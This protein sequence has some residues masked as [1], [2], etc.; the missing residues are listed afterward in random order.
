MIAPKDSTSLASNAILGQY[1]YTST[2]LRI[3][4]S[5]FGRR[6]ALIGSQISLQSH[7]R[8]HQ[9]CLYRQRQSPE[10][11]TDQTSTTIE[12]VDATVEPDTTIGEPTSTTTEPVTETDEPEAITTATAETTSTP[13]RLSRQR[14]TQRT[15]PTRHLQRLSLSMPQSSLIQQLQN[16]HHH[17]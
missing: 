11:T 15:Q 1:R 13:V 9:P 12:S 6:R 8:P 3:Q 17:N 14:Q 10:D 16:R 2:F 7:R 5:G 4:A